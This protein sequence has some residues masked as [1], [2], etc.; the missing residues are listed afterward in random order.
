MTKNVLGYS[1]TRK[2]QA[3][4]R[5]SV[6]S[7]LLENGCIP[8]IISFSISFLFQ[9]KC[10]VSWVQEVFH[11]KLQANLIVYNA[12]ISAYERSGLWQEAL[13]LLSQA[14]LNTVLA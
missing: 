12:T 8:Y 3:K 2:K 10:V 6:G 13:E 9:R 11:L 4:F 7:L 14:G 5:V 1:S